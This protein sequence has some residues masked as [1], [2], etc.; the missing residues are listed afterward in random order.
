MSAD[1]VAVINYYFDIHFD[2]SVLLKFF[3]GLIP[4]LSSSVGGLHFGPSLY[5]LS[6]ISE[7][8]GERYHKREPRGQLFASRRPQGAYK[9]T[10]T[11]A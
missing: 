8:S 5:F 6:A 10:R 4:W 3:G 1:E 9:Q 7:D 2:R 11:K